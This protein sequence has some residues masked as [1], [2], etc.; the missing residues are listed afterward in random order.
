MYGRGKIGHNWWYRRFRGCGYRITIPRESILDVLSRTDE[1]LSAEDIYLAVHKVHPTIGLTTIYRT[2]E[3]LVQMGLV[4]KF[5][6]GDGRARFELAEGPK[7]KRHH[8]HLVCSKCGRVID[9]TDFIDDEMEFLS[10]A[11]QGLAKKFHFDIT[12][13]VIQFYGVCDTCQGR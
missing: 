11:E 5:D 8:H 10:R 12:H 6:F 13:H 4:F 7:G 2:L 9:Y 1:H 3:I